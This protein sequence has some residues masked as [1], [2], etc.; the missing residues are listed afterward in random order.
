MSSYFLL[1]TNKTFQ[2]SDDEIHKYLKPLTEKLKLTWDKKLSNDY[3]EIAEEDWDEIG[4]KVPTKVLVFTFY[5][6]DSFDKG[7]KS[8][9][10]LN[11]DNLRIQEAFKRLQNRKVMRIYPYVNV[12]ELNAHYSRD[13]NGELHFNMFEKDGEMIYTCENFDIVAHESGHA[14]IDTVRPDF[15]DSLCLETGALHEAGGDLHVIFYLLKIP[16]A[17]QKFL[18]KTGG[19]LMVLSFISRIGE[20]L[21][22]GVEI[23]NAINKKTLYNVKNN[24]HDVSNVFTG[25]VYEILAKAFKK[26]KNMLF[27]IKIQDDEI[28]KKVVKDLSLLFLEAIITVPFSSP[29]FSDVGKKMQE[30]VNGRKDLNYI[31]NLIKPAFLGRGIDIDE[32][33]KERVDL[34]PL[35]GL[36]RPACC[37]TLIHFHKSFSKKPT[38]SQFFS[39]DKPRNTSMMSNFGFVTKPEKFTLTKTGKEDKANY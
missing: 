4:Q 8:L 24:V 9:L 7:M 6:A 27:G 32:P 34:N 16:E 25:A 2:L 33:H 3:F 1:P 11:P 36:S 19:D 17:R 39:D 20:S 29:L 5:L 37:K 35:N 13:N 23:R 18:E 14:N 10:K 15:N 30:I 26:L 31:A 28:L 22:E 12:N 38:F 21:M